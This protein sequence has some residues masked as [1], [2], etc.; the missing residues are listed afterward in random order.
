MTKK[1][2]NKKSQKV[3]AKKRIENLF[4]N[5]EK[6]ALEQDFTLADRYVKLARKISMRNLVS[7]PRQYKKKYCKH[8][9]SYLKPSINCRIRIHR[10]K[11]IIFCENCQKYT[12]IPLKN[13]K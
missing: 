3:I 9:Y 11:I 6:K 8:C 2:L 5:A 10:N 7:I 4:L 12:R 1:N 13:S